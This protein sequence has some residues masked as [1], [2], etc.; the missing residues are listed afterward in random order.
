MSENGGCPWPCCQS[1]FGIDNVAEYSNTRVHRQILKL[2]LQNKVAVEVNAEID[3]KVKRSDI[4]DDRKKTQGDGID[5]GFRHHQLSF[6][7]AVSPKPL[8]TA[9]S[10]SIRTVANCDRGLMFAQNHRLG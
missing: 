3:A 7:S 6:Y 1:R 2:S 9:H 5:E 10:R 8:Q 4:S